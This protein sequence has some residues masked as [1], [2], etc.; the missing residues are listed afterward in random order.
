MPR[1]LSARLHGSGRHRKP[2]ALSQVLPNV[3]DHT[4]TK[5]DRS[6]NLTPFGFV[7]EF[8]EQPSPNVIKSAQS[9]ELCPLVRK[10]LGI[11][12]ERGVGN[13]KTCVE[14]VAGDRRR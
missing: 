11:S 13:K 4:R 2:S 7:I 1:I 9:Y 6:R 3:H 8:S 5:L 10:P 14:R 12:G